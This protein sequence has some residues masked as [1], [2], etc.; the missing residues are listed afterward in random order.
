VLVIAREWS[1]QFEWW[2]HARLARRAGVAPEISAAIHERRDPPF[3]DAEERLVYRF[4]RELIDTRRVTDATYRTAVDQLGEA[5][6]TELTALLGYYTLV[7]LLLNTFAVPVPEGVD[8]P[9][10]EPPIP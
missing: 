8:P 7:S 10:L 5:G 1:A 6:V 2:A 3:Q 4:A 9:F